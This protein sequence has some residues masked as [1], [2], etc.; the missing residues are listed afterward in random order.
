MTAAL[1]AG[2]LAIVAADAVVVAIHRDGSGPRRETDAAPAIA[3]VVTPAPGDTAPAGDPDAT[4][5]VQAPAPGLYRYREDAPGGP[6]EFAERVTALVSP[7]GTATVRVLRTTGVDRTLGFTPSRELELADAQVGTSVADE[8]TCTESP[9]RV[10]LRLPLR[11]GSHWTSAVTCTNVLRDRVAQHRESRVTG[12]T[13]VTVGGAAVPAWEVVTIASDTTTPSG[14]G[15]A[16]TRV[17][18][19]TDDISARFGIT[20]REV[21]TPSP[22]GGSAR[23]DLLIALP[24]SAGTAT[25]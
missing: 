1:V 4:G 9:P 17:T 2:S 7:P 19:N 5:E 10:V 24:A 15:R 12:P 6:S 11:V 21:V 14:G 16:V 3:T 22:D 23:T 13:S 8:I 25:P 18:T 20:L